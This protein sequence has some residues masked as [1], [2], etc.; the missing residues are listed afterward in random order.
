MAI[1]PE[2]GEDWLRNLARVTESQPKLLAEMKSEILKEFR[3][4]KP[5]SEKS[6]QFY[7]ALYRVQY[8]M[9]IRLF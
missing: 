3:K 6:L 7:L 2:V 1:Y 4:T 9:F 8:T 5:P